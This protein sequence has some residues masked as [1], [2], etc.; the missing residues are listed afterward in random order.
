M[1][2][3]PSPDTLEAYWLGELSGADEA[4]FE[5]HLFACDGC[6]GRLEALAAL[7][8]GVRHLAERGAFPVVVSASLVELARQRGRRVREYALGPGE[9]VSCT[10]SATDD[11]VITRLRVDPSDAAR[12]DLVAELEGA[13]EPAT[14]ALDLP[15]ARG[16]GE[17][18][19]AQS[20]PALRALGPSVTRVRLVADGDRV[21]GEY[22][23]DHTPGD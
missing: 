2:A 5:E 12:I 19:V 7:G 8:G 18:L 17:L 21:L 20:V 13:S 10:V 23:F 1:S 11:M 16:A 14:R 4:G 6:T 22:T 9:R 15:F 3:C